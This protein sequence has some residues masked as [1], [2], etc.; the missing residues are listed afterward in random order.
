MTHGKGLWIIA[1]RWVSLDAVFVDQGLF[2]GKQY[3]IF[4]G[5]N[6]NCLSL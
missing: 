2:I 6:N 3:G 1:K 5:N 4:L